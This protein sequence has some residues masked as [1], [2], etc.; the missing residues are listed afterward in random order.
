MPSPSDPLDEDWCSVAEAAR[1]LNVT[2][3]AIRNRIKRGTLRA[4]PNG[5]IG[6][7][8]L[9]PRPEPV[10]LTPADAVTGTVPVTGSGDALDRVT[11]A[12][13]AE[14][15][16]RLSE[17]QARITAAEA[18]RIAIQRE[19]AQERAQA[20]EE[21]A[22]LQSALVGTGQRLAGLSEA[23]EAD[24]DRHRHEVDELRRELRDLRRR[25]W[26]QRVWAA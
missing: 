13:V 12:L 2:P 3:T 11:D 19:V 15:R 21:R 24:L 8:V 5:N 26:W 16:G 4:K 14:L 6:H 7:L 18:E 20:A 23:R 9:V 17:L 1:R 10:P 22:R 25:P